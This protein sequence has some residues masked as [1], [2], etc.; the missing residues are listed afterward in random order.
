[1]DKKSLN[2][3]QDKLEYQF[4]KLFWSKSQKNMLTIFVSLELSQRFMQQ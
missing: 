3:T 4:K 2:M 1:M